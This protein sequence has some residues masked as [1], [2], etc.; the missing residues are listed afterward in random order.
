MASGR[1]IGASTFKWVGELRF[2]PDEL[3]PHFATAIIKTQATGPK[4][5]NRV[6]CFLSSSDIASIEKE[7]R[8][9]LVLEAEGLMR[10]FRKTTAEAKL[11]DADSTKI[12]GKLDTTIVRFVMKKTMVDKFDNLTEIANRFAQEV[13]DISK[14]KVPRSW[15]PTPLPQTEAA[16]S[17]DVPNFVQFEAGVAQGARKLSLSHS[18]FKV[19]THVVSHEHVE[20]VI[21]SISDDGQVNIKRDKDSVQVAYADFVEQWKMNKSPTE[22]LENWQAQALTANPSYQESIAKAHLLSALGLLSVQAGLPQVKVQIKPSR[23]V[24]LQSALTKGK[25]AKLNLV[26]ETQRIVMVKKGVEGPVGGVK[27]SVSSAVDVDAYLMPLVS[28]TSIVPFWHCRQSENP[29]DA[30]M[31]LIHKK[32]ILVGVCGDTRVETEVTVPVLQNGVAL[33]AGAELVVYRPP[34]AAAKSTAKRSALCVAL[35]LDKGKKAKV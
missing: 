26:P 21:A 27:C 3:V 18:G 25:S 30:T 31:A 2:G 13:E 9:P 20:G 5:L 1:V 34:V 24:F 7:P 4:T 14:I 16:G 29:A 32:V 10:D 17:A 15:A 12:L 8:K 28:S 22:V 6:C 23:G 33:K 11:S 35:D 19:G